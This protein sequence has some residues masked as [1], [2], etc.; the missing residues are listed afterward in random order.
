[1]DIQTQSMAI[2]P[3]GRETGDTSRHLAPLLDKFIADDGNKDGIHRF[4]YNMHQIIS[5]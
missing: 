3:L 4:H 5:G 1:M 2:Y